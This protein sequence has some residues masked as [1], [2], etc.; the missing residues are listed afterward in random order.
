MTSFREELGIAPRDVDVHVGAPE[1]T[2]EDALEVAE[3]LD[4]VEQDVVGS[5]IAEPGVD[6]LVE[7]VR[8]PVWGVPSVIEGHLEDVLV[9]HAALAEVVPELPEDEEGLPAAS[10]SGDDL[11]E[12]VPLTF[13]ELPQIEVPL[14]L[15][16]LH[17]SSLY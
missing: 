8:T 5:V 12:P 9:I 6:I 2:I 17:A 16:R 7:H 14:Y 13:D 1:Q 10:D 11:D 4:L 3:H 15:A